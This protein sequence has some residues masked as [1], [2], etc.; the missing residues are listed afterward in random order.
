MITT[1]LHLTGLWIASIFLIAT[2]SEEGPSFRKK[3]FWVF[4]FPAGLY[5]TIW[6][7]ITF[8]KL[9]NFLNK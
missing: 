4:R 9:V 5:I 8:S 6:L 3:I 1:I 2:N 7:F